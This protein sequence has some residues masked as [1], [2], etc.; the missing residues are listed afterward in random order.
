LRQPAR[1][2]R[3]HVDVSD[4]ATA[5]AYLEDWQKAKAA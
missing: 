3:R 1:I 5:L 4:L 2:G